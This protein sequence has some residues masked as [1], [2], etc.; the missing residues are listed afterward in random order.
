MGPAVAVAALAV[1]AV[2]AYQQ[3]QQARKASRSA[4][5]AAEEQREQ[6][7]VGTA[8]EEIRA[9]QQRRQA[10]REQRIRRARILQA[11]E[12]AGVVD[13]SGQFGS[14]GSLGT[15]TGTTL[16]NIGTQR[17]GSRAIDASQE[18]QFGH[19]QSQLS[20]QQ[21]ASLWQSVGQVSGS[22][23]QAAGGFPGLSDSFRGT[24]NPSD[25]EV[26]DLRP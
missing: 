19:Y 13:S 11:S 6:Q 1:T 3:H 22:I 25:I 17:A 12:G 9:R 16:G 4:R 10:L 24:G 23:F 20:A 5:R 26:V 7:R 21:R 8:A 15:L 2:S 14:T 18:R